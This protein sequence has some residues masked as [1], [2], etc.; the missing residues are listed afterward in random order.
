MATSSDPDEKRV[1]D[2]MRDA[3]RP[4]SVNDVFSNLHKAVGK[5]AIQRAL[6]SLVSAG[7]INEK[8]YGKQKVYVVKQPTASSSNSDGSAPTNALP[9]EAEKRDLETRAQTAERELVVEQAEVKKLQREL[10]TLRQR[11]TCEQLRARLAELQAELA[12]K[13]ERLAAIDSGEGRK[14]TPELMSDARK[15]RANLVSEWRKRKRACV[16]L[17]DCV[18]E[19][20]PASKKA[21]FEEV[22]LETD[23]EHNAVVPK[24]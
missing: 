2:Y 13:T 22:G 5:T 1:L 4:Y 21:F 18:L 11:P 10:A 6:D 12:P 7:L 19:G 8:T 17:I 20:Y 14:V 3:N 15:I 16:D 23:E 9:D 24:V